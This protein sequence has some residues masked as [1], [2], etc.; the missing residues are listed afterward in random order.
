LP[1][2]VFVFFLGVWT[3]ELLAENPVPESVSRAIPDEWKFWLAKGLHVVAYA[4]LTVLAGLL[5]VPRVYFWLVVA[6]LVLHGVGTEVGQR[7]VANRHGSLRDV[8]LDWAGVGL[9]LLALW[10]LKRL[11]VVTS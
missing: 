11:R 2:A 5:P 3:Y 8:I 1:F 7:Y 4:V 9:G 6:F 10:V